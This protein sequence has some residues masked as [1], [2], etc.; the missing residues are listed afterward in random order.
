MTLIDDKIING[1]AIAKELLADIANR[2]Q[3]LAKQNTIPKLSI[4]LVGNNDAS[5]VYVENKLRV[6]EQL[7]VRTQLLHMPAD[8]TQTDL[9]HTINELNHDESV[10]AILLQLPLP[11]QINQD[12]MISAIKPEKDV[13]GFH[14]INCGYLHSGVNKGF[15]PCIHLAC[16][17]LIKAVTDDITGK[18][19]AIIGRSNIV[20]KPL[21]ALL[22]NHNATVTLCH[23]HT[24]N[25]PEIT[26]AA[27]IAVTAT[28][29]AKSFG[30]AY[31]S[32]QSI[33]IDVGINR[34]GK[35]LCGDVD[36]E[37]V[38]NMVRAITPVP[39]GV[40]PMT[41]AYLMSNT[42]N[43]ASNNS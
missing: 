31:F 36:F 27:D 5:K 37:E 26:R 41:I 38:Y 23:S 32:S 28:G 34:D 30:A 19:I 43:A 2:V 25:L 9:H 1:S 42:V 39:G 4:I 6:A 21:A 8:T 35:H 24:K 17:H 15:I 20:G 18:N 7:A 10:H 14:P 29:Q 3:Q 40:G 11:K 16:L 33:I 13:D 12:D 22:T